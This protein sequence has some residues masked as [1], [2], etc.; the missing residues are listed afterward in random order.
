MAQVIQVYKLDVFKGYTVDFRLKEFRKMEY[1]KKIEFI[2]FQTPKGKRLLAQY[3]A[4]QE[5]EFRRKNIRE[6]RRQNP[7]KWYIF[8]PFPWW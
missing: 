2:A 8:G 4:K 3:I 5:K 7:R 1:P 6:F